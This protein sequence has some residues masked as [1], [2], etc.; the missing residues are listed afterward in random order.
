MYKY[1]RIFSCEGGFYV[2]Y[3][4]CKCSSLHCDEHVERVEGCN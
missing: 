3:M 4:M 2:D 1:E